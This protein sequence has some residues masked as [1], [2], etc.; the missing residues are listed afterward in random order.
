MPHPFDRMHAIPDPRTLH[1]HLADIDVLEV[2][3]ARLLFEGYNDNEP[4]VRNTRAQPLLQCLFLAPAVRGHHNRHVVLRLVDADL[5]P[6]ALTERNQCKRDRRVAHDA[7]AWLGQPRL[8]EDLERAAGQARV[9]DGHRALFG[10][11]L[12]VARDDPQHER[13][14]RLEHAQRV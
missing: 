3:N 8:E 1:R 14:A 13:L 10:R 6:K 7:D 4:D 9:L 11:A 12:A 5:V 2:Y